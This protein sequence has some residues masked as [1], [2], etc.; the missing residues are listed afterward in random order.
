[1]F[2]YRNKDGN[3]CLD[4]H[5]FEL[6]VNDQIFEFWARWGEPQA[7][8]IDA[9]KYAKARLF[10]LT[11]AFDSNW[12]AGQQHRFKSMYSPFTKN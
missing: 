5:S 3:Y 2:V 10:L 9:N 8:F 12:T 6:T 4:M 1:M 11:A 7:I